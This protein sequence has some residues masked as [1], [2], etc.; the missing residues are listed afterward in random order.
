MEE[1]K[2]KVTEKL[3]EALKYAR[4]GADIKSMEYKK[5][6]CD[7]YVTVTYDNGYSKRINVTADSGKALIAD[8]ISNL[9]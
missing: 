4:I 9:T 5:E 6:N 2:E 1:N 3:L 8:V 7:E